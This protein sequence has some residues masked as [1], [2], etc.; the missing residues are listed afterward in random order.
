MAAN[1]TEETIDEKWRLGGGQRL[2]TV[3]FIP[4]TANLSASSLP[5]IPM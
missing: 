1:A 3:L 2:A 5:R 4:A